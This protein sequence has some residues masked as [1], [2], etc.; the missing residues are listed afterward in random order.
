P[1]WWKL[2]IMP[3]AKYADGKIEYL[4]ITV[5]DATAAIL[6]E[7]RE[8]ELEA[9]LVATNEELAATNEE[10]T[11]TIDDLQKAHRTLE[12]LNQELEDRIADRI[13]A[14]KKTEHNLRSLVMSAHYPLMI[15]RGREWIIEIANQP[16]VNLWDRTI[17]EVTGRRL[18]DI[19]PELDDQI[20][21]KLL[22]QVY[23][24]GV[25]YGQE[26]QLFYYK[27][28][29]GIVKKYVSFYYDPLPGE[30]G[31]IDGIIVTAN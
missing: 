30:N 11:A 19:L 6:A 25:P 8:Q 26:E 31:T 5:E 21:P 4:L 20:F 15:L 10:L 22:R 2:D 18:M 24:T 1:C 12:L 7:H 27:T 16:L 17:E 9:E 23:E 14:L 28:E 13:A 29:K 3:V